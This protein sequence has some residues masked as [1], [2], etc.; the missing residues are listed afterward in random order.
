[1]YS[2]NVNVDANIKKQATAILND[3]GVNLSTYINMALTQVV[4]RNG[5]P[6]EVK[7]PKPS[8]ALLKALKEGEDILKGKT[9]AK[10]YTNMN[11]MLK[12]LKS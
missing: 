4:K 10:S 2:I 7:N 9:K 12:D 3:L 8:K 11:E 1:M 5:I 6:F